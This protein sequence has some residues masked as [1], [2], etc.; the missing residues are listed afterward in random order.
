MTQ[1]LSKSA[2]YSNVIDFVLIQFNSGMKKQ[3]NIIP[4]LA[5][6]DFHDDATINHKSKNVVN[7]MLWIAQQLHILVYEGPSSR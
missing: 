5:M 6:M 4:S 1:F 7:T 3:N 2:H